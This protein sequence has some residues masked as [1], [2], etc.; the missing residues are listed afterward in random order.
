MTSACQ[1]PN[2]R[3][4]ADRYIIYLIAAIAIILA[5]L[6]WYSERL[7]GV[8]QAAEERGDLIGSLHLAKQ[9]VRVDPLSV[10]ALF[11]VAGAQQQMG[12]ETEARNALVKATELEP[13][14]YAT[15]ETLAFYERDRWGQPQLAREH[16]QKAW[17]L[18]PYDE[19]LREELGIEESDQ[20]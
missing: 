2:R 17:E 16:L 15:W 11:V 7:Q 6:P 10:K 9:A 4:P 18:N 1:N 20:P 13:L 5:I 19:Q 3:F 8:S 12:R 14:N